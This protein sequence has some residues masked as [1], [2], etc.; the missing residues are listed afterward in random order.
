MKIPHTA[1]QQTSI[2][3]DIRNLPY[4]FGRGDRPWAL[5][6]PRNSQVR[7]GKIACNQSFIEMHSTPPLSP[8]YFYLPLFNSFAKKLL[9]GRKNSGRIFAPPPFP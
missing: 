1:Y 7:R 6:T 5:E 3:K 4:T 9:L 8:Q 2:L